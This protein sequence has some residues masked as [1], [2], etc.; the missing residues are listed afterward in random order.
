MMFHVSG[1]FKK[2]D[3]NNDGFMDNPLSKQLNF[4]NIFKFQL[5]NGIEG[6]FGVNTL[7][8]KKQG[9]QMKFQENKDKNIQNFYGTNMETT[10]IQIWNKT[11]YIFKQKPYQSMG[12][13]TQFVYHQHDSYFGDRNYNG[14]EKSF[15]ANYIFESILGNTNHIYKVGASF[16]YDDYKEDYNQLDFLKT[17]KVPGLFAE[18]TYKYLEKFTLVAGSRIDF[19]SIAGTQ[20]TPRINIKYNPIE[21][22]TLR[23]SAGRSFRTANILPL[24]EI[25][26]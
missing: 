20:F 16:L 23:I 18:Y 26:K 2:M 6:M 9:G 1:I 22:T 25:L 3:G 10:R 7:Y 12:L 4:M 24:I 14:I 13:Q 8:D 11:G 17:E 5:H 21:K 19:H 15:Y